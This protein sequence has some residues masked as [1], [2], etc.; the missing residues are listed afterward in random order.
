[1]KK[2]VNDQNN[3]GTDKKKTVKKPVAASIQNGVKKIA[4]IHRH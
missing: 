3:I 1:M 4:N 2:R